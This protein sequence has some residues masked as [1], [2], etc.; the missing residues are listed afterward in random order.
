MCNAGQPNYPDNAN[1][2]LEVFLTVPGSYVNI[3]Y[4]ISIEDQSACAYD[5]LT[6]GE[7]RVDSVQICGTHSGQFSRALF[8]SY[9]LPSVPYY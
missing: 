9:G 1:W 3:R 6:L 4:N 7:G 2:N 5:K 8:P